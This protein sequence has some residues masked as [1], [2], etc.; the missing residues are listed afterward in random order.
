MGL[1]TRP[2]KVGWVEQ[3]APPRCTKW[4]GS[5]HSTHPTS[6]PGFHHEIP[7]R[8][9]HFRRRA[10]RITVP[11]RRRNPHPR[12]A[13]RQL[14]RQRRE[15]DAAERLGKCVFPYLAER[16]AEV[17]GVTLVDAAWA[18]DLLFELPLPRRRRARAVHG[19]SP[20]L[21]AGR[22]GGDAR[23][24]RSRVRLPRTQVGR[25]AAGRVRYSVQCADGRGRLHGGRLPGS[26]TPP[27]RRGPAD[28]RGKARP[29]SG[30]GSRLPIAMLRGHVGEQLGRRAPA[31]PASA[32]GRRPAAAPPGRRG[33]RR[34]WPL[35]RRSPQGRLAP[36]LS[37]P[38]APCAA[39]GARHAVRRAGLRLP[40]REQALS[41]A[42]WKTNYGRSSNRSRATSW[43]TGPSR[44]RARRGN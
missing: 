11:A 16:L 20:R 41:G 34:R 35:G 6:W 30:P 14:H 5:L 37:Q 4:W 9:L 28:A 32:L 15:L 38:G 24:A 10:G 27:G 8:N 7:P 1:R 23:R 21:A 19:R 13:G 33:G 18:R 36:Q 3:R 29:R 12:P 2:E 26:A 22:S 43:T 42:K 25:A 31:D 44:G 39:R 40:P 17:P